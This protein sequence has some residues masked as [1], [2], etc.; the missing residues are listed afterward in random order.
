MRAS[1]RRRN[2]CEAWIILPHMWAT[3]EDLQRAGAYGSHA[4]ISRA[5]RRMR[6][7][8]WTDAGKDFP[9]GCQVW[10]FT[11]EGLSRLNF[12]PA[13]K[14]ET[15]TRMQALAL[16]HMHD[17]TDPGQDMRHHQD[18]GGY[19]QAVQALYRRRWIDESGLTELGIKALENADHAHDAG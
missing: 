6:A 7:A 5:L 9:A 15:P 18:W 17:G 19:H 3:V 16:R 1:R 4:S 10:R 8:G 11:H 14:S 13:R 2:I 12:V